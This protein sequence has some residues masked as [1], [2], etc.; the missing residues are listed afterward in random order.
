MKF[1]GENQTIRKSF[2]RADAVA[3]LAGDRLFS[4]DR[5]VAIARGGSKISVQSAETHIFGYAI[6]IDL[7]R[8]DLQRDGGGTGQAAS[9]ARTAPARWMAPP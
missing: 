1:F 7:T 8:R 9:F 5:Q 2:F 4:E 6:G 3:G